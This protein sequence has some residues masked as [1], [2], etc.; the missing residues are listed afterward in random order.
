V[1]AWDVEF[2]DDAKKDRDALSVSVRTQVN[3]AIYKTA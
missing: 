3:K 1:R 2:T